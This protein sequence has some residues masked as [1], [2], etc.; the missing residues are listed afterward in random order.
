MG[1]SQEQNSYE[2]AQGFF[3][4]ISSLNWLCC[5]IGWACSKAG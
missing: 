2:T 3:F 5:T 4:V 1:I